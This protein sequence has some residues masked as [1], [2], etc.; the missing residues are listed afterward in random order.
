VLDK[1]SNTVPSTP[2]ATPAPAA[3]STTVNNTVKQER[4]DGSI[5]MEKVDELDSVFSPGVADSNSADVNQRRSSIVSNSENRKELPSTAA[6]DA[7]PISTPGRSHRNHTNPSVADQTA[8]DSGDHPKQPQQQQL[9]SWCNHHQKLVG[10]LSCVIQTISLSC[11]TSLIYLPLA[12]TNKP[13]VAR[14][15]KD[16][17]LLRILPF[18]ISNLPMPNGLSEDRRKQVRVIPCQINKKNPHR[19]QFS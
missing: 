16:Y 1:P 17:S 5:K 9:F 12:E 8:G 14:E 13:A 3:P 7:Q 11:T 19:F 15:D 18:S 6:D 4:G 10:L 2:A